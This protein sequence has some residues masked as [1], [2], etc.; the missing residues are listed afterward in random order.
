M[1]TRHDKGK[2]GEILAAE[3]LEQHGLKM[4]A[5]NFRCP[6]GEIDLIGRDGK[7]IV[8][9]EVKSRS[10][11]SY[12]LPQDAVTR[13]KQ[14]RLTH[15]ARWYLKRHGLEREPARFDVVAIIWGDGAPELTWIVNAFEAS[16]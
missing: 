13:S 2:K 5:Q 12:G 4:V 6:L 7:T 10:T 11:T 1:V 9:I 16:D 3:Y 15:L 14:R 8:F